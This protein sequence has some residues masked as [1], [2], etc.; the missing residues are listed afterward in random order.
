MVPEDFDEIS[1]ATLLADS[2]EVNDFRVHCYYGETWI[3]CEEDKRFV[4]RQ[5]RIL[6]ETNEFRNWPV[7][8]YL[9]PWMLPNMVLGGCFAIDRALAVSL[10][11]FDRAFTGYGFTETSLA[12]KAV[13]IS[14]TYVVPVVNGPCIHI[15]DKELVIPRIE[16]D[17][18]F[19]ERHRF[20]FDE[21][22]D[23]DLQQA[24]EG[25]DGTH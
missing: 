24:I 4:G 5:F 1:C 9:G 3:G 23:L 17:R 2:I 22:L 13:A 21:Y 8:G 12:T 25:F 11:G 14:N 18:I 19:W 16:K 7:G 20:F 15:E 6:E 10:G